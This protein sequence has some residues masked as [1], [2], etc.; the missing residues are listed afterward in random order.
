MFVI[1]LKPRVNKIYS[2]CK[3]LVKSVYARLFL[4]YLTYKQIERQYENN[5]QK[6]LSEKANRNIQ[7]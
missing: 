4:S 3:F 1:T 2:D 7:E 5:L 6:L